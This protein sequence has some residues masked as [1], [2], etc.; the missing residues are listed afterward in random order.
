M[1][2]VWYLWIHTVRSMAYILTIQY[3]GQ[4]ESYD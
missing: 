4:H 2:T 3:G 1:H